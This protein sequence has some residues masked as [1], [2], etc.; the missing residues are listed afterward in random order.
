[1]SSLPGYSNSIW[2]EWLTLEV[3]DVSKA[4]SHVCDIALSTLFGAL[5]AV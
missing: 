4:H 3:I 5:Y 2:Q 1:M